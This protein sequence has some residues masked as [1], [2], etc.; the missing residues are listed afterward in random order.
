MAV[1]ECG[2]DLQRFRQQHPVAEH[3]AR[4]IATADN[5]DRLCLHI[6]AKF[7]EVALDGDPRALGGNPHRLVVVTDTAPR[8]EGITQPEMMLQCDGIGDIAERRGSLIGGNDEIGVFAVVNDD[9]GGVH[10]FALDDIVGDRQQGPDEDAV[11]LGPFGQPRIAVGGGIG[12]HLGKEPAFCTGRYDD[13]VLDPLRLHQAQNFGTEIVAPVGPA[14]SAARHRASAQVDALHAR[15]VHPN[16]APRH[17]RGQAGYFRAVELERNRGLACGRIEIGAERGADNGTEQSQH[18]VLVDRRNLRQAALDGGLGGL[19][20]G[21]ALFRCRIVVRGK[22]INDRAGDMRVAAQRLDHGNQAIGEAGLAQ[23]AEHRAQQ[24]DRARIER[25]GHNQL[26]EPVILRRSFKHGGDCALDN[27]VARQ[28]RRGIARTQIEYEPVHVPQ[29]PVGEQRRDFFDDAEPEVFE[30]GHNVGQGNGREAVKLE[31]QPALCIGL[32]AIQP[33]LPVC[34]GVEFG[35]PYN[36]AR[37]LVGSGAGSIER[38]K[39]LGI[40]QRQ[41]RRA[42]VFACCDQARF[43]RFC[44]TAHHRD[45]R[46]AQL[47][48]VGF[49]HRLPPVESVADQRNFA[50]A[51]IN[52]PIEQR[53]VTG[54]GQHRRNCD[55]PRRRQLVAGQPDESEHM[56]VERI[57]GQHQIG[58]RAVGQR[59]RRQR[60]AFKHCRINREQ[61]IMRQVSQ[62]VR[63]RLA[64][65]AVSR[66]PVFRHQRHQPLAQHRNVLRCGGQRRAG[67]KPRMDTDTIGGGQHDEVERRAAVNGRQEIRLGEHWP[68]VRR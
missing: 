40:A 23:I 20:Q 13:G 44:P 52:R 4:H 30:R 64:R 21:I 22:Q 66:E 61:Q 33:H 1:V 34:G 15:T 14:Q 36:I 60:E 62:R 48:L 53:P 50:V 31:S 18:A 2:N 55:A 43:N 27:R 41:P 3:V 17:G 68:R 45:Q 39:R 11:A 32:A 38:G 51:Q 28:Q 8:G 6:G 46:H 58:T 65:M 26:V 29:C 7:G 59:H 37:C 49:A 25:G 35:E 47:S 24:H 42:L 9:V 67:P 10:H 12:Q 16:L 57:A 56:A 54:V 19:A 5:A 63:E